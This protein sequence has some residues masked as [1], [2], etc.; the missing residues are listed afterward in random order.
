LE[1]ILTEPRNLIIASEFI[2]IESNSTGIYWNKIINAL[3]E[4]GIGIK[5]ISSKNSILKSQLEHAGI[6]TMS[7][8]PL[9]F[10][11]K[12]FFIS[13]FNKIFMSFA[14]LIKIN[15]TLNQNDLLLTGTNPNI[16]IVLIGLLNSIKKFRWILLVHDLFPENLIPGGMLSKK[17]LL[18]KA[19]IRLFDFA[20]TKPCH[21]IS[22]GRD[23]TDILRNK[24]DSKI[25][26]IPNFVDTKDIKFRNLS[27]EDEC[28]SYSYQGN[29]GKLQDIENIL[30]AITL[31]KERRAKFYFSGQGEYEEKVRDFCAT[32]QRLGTKFLDKG[33]DPHITDV[34]IIPL[35]KGMR[36][37][38]VPS[39]AYFSIGNDKPLLIIGDLGSELNLMINENDGLGWF[40]NAGNPNELA[41]C[42]ESITR[43]KLNYMKGKPRSIAENKYSFELAAK[44]YIRVVN[45][46]I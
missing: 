17:N 27:N 39:K 5:V 1:G 13:S 34:A 25:S 6:E 33:I 23:M 37:L 12:N 9:Q 19:L 11:P 15:K 18:Y 38:A 8:N 35:K 45:E 36:G 4:S 20:Y 31:L 28:I 43:D 44:D 2:D 41:R 26:F 22:I 40:V 46:H 24:T 21:L 7:V 16:V 10:R 14:I 30:T 32:H 29:L 3:N 42:I